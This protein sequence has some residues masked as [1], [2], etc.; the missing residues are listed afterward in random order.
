MA[1]VPSHMYDG[2]HGG[3]RGICLCF[4]IQTSKLAFWFWRGRRGSGNAPTHPN[5]PPQGSIMKPS[6]KES[7]SVV[8]TIDEPNTACTIDM[9]A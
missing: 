6:T 2:E 5:L 8:M 4:K 9:G 3:G 7:D 1:G